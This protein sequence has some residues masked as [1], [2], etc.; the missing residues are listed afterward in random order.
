MASA[1]TKNLRDGKILVLTAQ[2]WKP[3]TAYI[4]TD[5]VRPT[6]GKHNGFE[7]VCT[8]AGTSGVTEPTWPLTGTV[9][10]GTPL[11]W[12]TQAI[13]KG[14]TIDFIDKGSF[15]FTVKKNRIITRDRGVLAEH[16][17]SDEE[18]VEVSFDALYTRLKAD[19]AEVSLYELLFRK[20]LAAAYVSQGGANEVWS[21]H[22]VL[23][24]RDD[25]LAKWEVMEF[26]EFTADLDF[27]EGD[28]TNALSV[29]GT[30]FCTAPT[31]SHLAV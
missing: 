30:S 9:T 8:T 28:E 26:P 22:L 1:C 23:C 3:S 11:V 19:T 2:A 25:L 27:N 31:L 21:V 16:R 14:K 24:V 17:G 18:P 10:D 6:N 13:T 29:K 4:L 5:V 12:T 20:G 7:Y 15:K